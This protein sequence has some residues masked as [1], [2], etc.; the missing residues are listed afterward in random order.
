MLPVLRLT[1]AGASRMKDLTSAIA[2]EFKLTAEEVAEMQPSGRMR[3]LENRAHWARWYLKGAGLVRPVK[4]GVYEITERGRALLDERPERVDMKLLERFEEY[5]EWRERTTNGRSGRNR[6]D[7]IID[8]A[9]SGAELQT[10]QDRIDAAVHEIESNLADTLLDRLIDGS[11]RFFE[12]AVVDL[13]L[14]MGYGRG[15]EGAGQRL[16]RSGD[17]GIDGVINEDALGL[18][19]VY[20]QA[21]RYGLGNVVGRPAIQQFVGSLTGEGAT[22]GVFVT[23]SNF[24]TDARNFVNKISQRIVLIDGQQFARLMIAH[25]VGVRGY[26]AITLSEVDENFFTE[27]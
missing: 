22:K 10:P 3:V 12:K 1:G 25:G 15:R 18:D 4:R 13:L 26:Q 8:R 14:A 24:S 21:K 11:P 20:V 7:S 2:D 9:E 23:T 27:E 17:G 6:E 19:A 16:G 5:R